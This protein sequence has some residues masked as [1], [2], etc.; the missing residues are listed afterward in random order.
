MKIKLGQPCILDT[1]ETATLHPANN[2]TLPAFLYS[3]ATLT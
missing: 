1:Y 2:F 3:F